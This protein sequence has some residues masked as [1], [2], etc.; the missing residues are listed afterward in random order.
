MTIVYFVRSAACENPQDLTSAI[1][2]TGKKEIEAINAFFSDKEIANLFV[3]NEKNGLTT[4]ESLIQGEKCKVTITEEFNERKIGPRVLNLDSFT[5]NQFE[6]PE[7]SLPEGESF[8]E[9]QDRMLDGLERIVTEFENQTS[10]IC[11]Q[12][13]SLATV[14]TFFDETFS[15]EEYQRTKQV[16]PWIVKMKFEGRALISLEE[17]RC[18]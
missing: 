9:T 14:I 17:I 8:F 16:T 6:R 12:S 11:T 1:T 18:M 7:Y 2:A 10:L 5:R 15:F 3:C 4:M 13:M